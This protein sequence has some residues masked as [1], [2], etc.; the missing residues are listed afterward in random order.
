MRRWKISSL[1]LV[2]CCCV[3]CSAGSEA[4]PEHRLSGEYAV[5]TSFV[6]ISGPGIGAAEQEAA[7]ARFA[8]VTDDRQ[9]FDKPEPRAGAQGPMAN[10]TYERVSGTQTSLSFHASCPPTEQLAAMSVSGTQSTSNYDYTVTM[11]DRLGVVGV[12]REQGRRLG[13]CPAGSTGPSDNSGQER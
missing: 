6:S 12:S 10:C 13:A 2:P 3:A 11:T 4:A 8:A 9:C 7:R 5:T 1:F